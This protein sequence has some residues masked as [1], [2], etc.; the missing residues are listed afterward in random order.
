[1]LK[2]TVRRNVKDAIC[3]TNQNITVHFIIAKCKQYPPLCRYRFKARTV[4]G[5]GFDCRSL[6]RLQFWA[7]M[8]GRG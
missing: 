4:S 7:A 6:P 8:F 2:I 1:M 3:L 5:I